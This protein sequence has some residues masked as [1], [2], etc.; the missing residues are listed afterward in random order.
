MDSN[1]PSPRPRAPLPVIPRAPSRTRNDSARHPLP[2]PD[3]PL[4]YRRFARAPSK[5]SLTHLS[6]TPKAAASSP[7]RKASE[8]LKP[9]P[10]RRAGL[11]SLRMSASRGSRH[12]PQ[13]IKEPG[14]VGSW[15]GQAVL[16]GP[17]E[18]PYILRRT[19]WE[20]DPACV[21]SSVVP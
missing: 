1:A 20:R 18:K 10:Q 16:A 5:L 17:L 6:R 11:V 14:R 9:R 2:A 12:G 21:R 19:A 7:R 4:E 3:F 13:V 15:K 8:T